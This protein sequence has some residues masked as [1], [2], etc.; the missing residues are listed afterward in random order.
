MFSGERIRVW[1]ADRLVLD[2]DLDGEDYENVVRVWECGTWLDAV[3]PALAMQMEGEER[4]SS[5]VH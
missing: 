3:V 1:A 5:R 4:A 2:V